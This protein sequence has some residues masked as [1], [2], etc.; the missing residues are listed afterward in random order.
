VVAE[1]VGSLVFTGLA[2]RFTLWSELPSLNGLS[3]AINV[4][5]AAGSLLIAAII[6]FQ[7]RKLRT[8]YENSDSRV[9]KFMIFAVNTGGLTAACALA[10]LITILAFPHALIYAAFYFCLGKLYANAMLAYLNSRKSVDGEPQDD[11]TALLEFAR[12]VKAEA[13][14]QGGAA[15]DKSSIEKENKSPV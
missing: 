4:I 7:L 8:G 2:M 10:S 12:E 13:N 14:A 5:A 1:F 6:V 3:Q 11:D 15:N 9:T